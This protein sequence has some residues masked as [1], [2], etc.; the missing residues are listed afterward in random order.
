MLLALRL[1]LNEA[2]ATGPR[3]IQASQCELVAGFIEL[4]FGAK[5]GLAALSTKCWFEDI[6]VN[7]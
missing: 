2:K 3:S 6:H 7:A 5:M 1:P 4:G